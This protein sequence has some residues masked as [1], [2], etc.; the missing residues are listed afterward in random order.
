MTND[1]DSGEA[2]QPPGKIPCQ[3]TETGERDENDELEWAR[4]H[5]QQGGSGPDE[6]FRK[7]ELHDRPPGSAGFRPAALVR[8][9]QDRIIE[10]I[11]DRLDAIDNRLD[12]IEDRIDH[13]VGRLSQR[14]HAIEKKERS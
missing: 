11:H 10:K 1:T 12:D 4:K 8:S 9:R 13:A 5:V 6:V 3:E 7:T 14:I 2:E